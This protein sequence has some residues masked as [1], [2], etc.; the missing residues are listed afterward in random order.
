MEPIMDRVKP[1]STA[2]IAW[3]LTK[4]CFERSYVLLFCGVYGNVAQFHTPDYL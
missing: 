1:T 2:D 3:A 4:Y